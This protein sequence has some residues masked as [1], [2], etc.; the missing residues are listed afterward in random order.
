MLRLRYV[1]YGLGLAAALLFLYAVR[2]I[3]T[4]FVL[5][6]AIAYLASPLV[7][8]LEARQV[9]R[10]AAILLVY[11]GFAL[12]VSIFFYAF[13]PSLIAELN[14]VLIS[15]PRQTNRIEDLT[16]GAVGDLKRLPLPVNLQQAINN[17][18]QR[19]EQL[20]QQFARQ[21]VDFLV[22]VFSKLLW[23]LLAPVLAYYILLDWDDVGR[24]WLEAVP[25]SFRPAFV[26]LI[27]EIDGVLTGFVLGRLT[28]S[29]IVGVFITL[30][31]VLLDIQF[32]VLLGL[33]AGIF[34]LIPYLGPVLGGI[35]AVMLAFL[36][37]P[38]KALWVVLLFAAVNQL[39]AVIL[40]P[41]ILGARVG[42]HPVVTIFALMA[43]GHL[44]GVGGILLAVPA[45]AAL[46]VVLSFVGRVLRV[47]D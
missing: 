2:G 38:W 22:G 8:K 14:Q 47:C 40:S 13:I 34:D 20:I 37:S 28:I 32:A 21:L 30:G 9:P 3:L 17:M 43:G 11:L 25:D 15:L 19:S 45:A 27:Q 31:L 24:R 5:G 10:S 16:R 41:R 23:L 6:G 12:V 29:V 18:I 42:L 7:R 35:P 26:L 4:P 33:I 1:L 36:S 46:R 39:E 44:F